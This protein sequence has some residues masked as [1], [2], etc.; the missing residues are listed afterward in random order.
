M[1]LPTE[2]VARK[3][4]HTRSIT[5]EVYEREDGLWDLEAQLIDIKAYDFPLQKGGVHK[6]GD[7]VHNMR[8]CLTLNSTYTIVA[9][10]VEYLAAPYRPCSQIANDYQQ[11]IGLNL[12]HKF[13]HEV[14][15][16]FARAKGC[17]HMTELI[18]VLPTAAI[19]AMAPRLKSKAVATDEPLTRPYHID[20][21]HAMRADGEVVR[22][23]YP[24]WYEG[25][26]AT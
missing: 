13:R 1:A 3:P 7:P 12:L 8:L 15:V 4:L 20:G 24:Q 22:D 14:R 18:N 11:L 19:Q 6:A 25:V 2:K 5:M 10:Q 16:R 17:T 21:C 9:V 23:Y 26:N